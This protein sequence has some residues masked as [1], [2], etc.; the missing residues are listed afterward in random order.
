MIHEREVF[1]GGDR[2][3]VDCYVVKGFAG[4]EADNTLKF[5]A[6]RDHEEGSVWETARV[7]SGELGFVDF[8]FS[9][10]SMDINITCPEMA[11]AVSL[12]GPKQG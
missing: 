12:M 8:G 1:H 9:F 4:R 11:T 10:L 2:V 6:G 5:E 7:V 3:S